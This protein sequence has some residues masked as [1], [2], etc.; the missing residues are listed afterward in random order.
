MGDVTETGELEKAKRK[1]HGTE[2][3]SFTLNLY[4]QIEHCLLLN[5]YV[6]CLR[7]KEMREMN[8]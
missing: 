6:S 2:W 3:M 5:F 1:K 4:R 8:R 7:K